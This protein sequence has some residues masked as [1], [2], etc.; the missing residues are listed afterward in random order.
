MRTSSS[1]EQSSTTTIQSLAIQMSACI[2][3]GSIK[4]DRR[5]CG[6]EHLQ[7]AIRALKLVELAPD[8]LGASHGKISE[9]PLEDVSRVL[10]VC[11][12]I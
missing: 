10:L 12:V 3:I 1:N 4:A 9:D 8:G 5:D 7:R 6:C 2:H 11:A